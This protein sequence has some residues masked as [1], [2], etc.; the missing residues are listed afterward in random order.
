MTFETEC[1]H[2]NNPGY[3]TNKKK[4]PMK[5]EKSKKALSADW[6]RK[7]KIQFSE[8]SIDIFAEPL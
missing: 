8:K 6:S 2:S 4:V 5:K 7:S 1:N 3:Q